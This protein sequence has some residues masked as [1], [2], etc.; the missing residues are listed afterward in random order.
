MPVEV[1]LDIYSGRP[2]PTWVL[3]EEESR[4]IRLAV[5]DLVATEELPASVSRLGYRG[6]LLREIIMPSV[7]SEARVFGGT[8]DVPREGEVRVDKNRSLE[9]RLLETMPEGYP[10]PGLQSYL[11]EQVAS[12]IPPTR[13]AVRVQCPANMGGLSP[14]Y[15]PATWNIPTV[16]GA[17]NCYNYANNKI[18]NSFAQPG[19]GSGAVFTALA[20]GDVRDAAVRD[21][22]VPTASVSNRIEDGFYV[23][24]VIWPGEDFHWFRQDREGCWSHKPGKDPATNLDDAG[25]RITDPTTCDRGDYSQFCTYMVTGPRTVIL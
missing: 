1:E 24:L 3:L 16:Q 8:V 25:M 5:K 17:N 13:R 15:S 10:H 7:V 19:K 6:F 12:P 2:N 23:A 21:G 14:A 20:C 11:V 18:T 9:R 22:L 4:A